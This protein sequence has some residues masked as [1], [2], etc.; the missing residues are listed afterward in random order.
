M[1]LA[2]AR[3]ATLDKMNMDIN[4][5]PGGAA[6]AKPAMPGPREPIIKYVARDDLMPDIIQQGATMEFFKLWKEQM[7]NYF[8]EAY[9][10]KVLPQPLT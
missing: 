7:L 8:Q 9:Q 5:P 10:T 3:S 2:S 4:G 6:F 1:F